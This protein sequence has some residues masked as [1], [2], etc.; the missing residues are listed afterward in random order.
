V[1]LK[2][3]KERD[4]GMERGRDRAVSEALGRVLISLSSVLINTDSPKNI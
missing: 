2:L 4:R 3:Q 1:D